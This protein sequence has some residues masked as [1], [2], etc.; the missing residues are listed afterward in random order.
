MTIITTI[1]LWLW[2]RTRRDERGGAMVL[3][4]SAIAVVGVLLLL[5]FLPPARTFMTDVVDWVRGNTI[6]S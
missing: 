1:G 5:A 3:E 2:A 4:M 6:A